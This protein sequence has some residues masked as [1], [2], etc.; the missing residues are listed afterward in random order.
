MRA[1]GGA[2][3]GGDSPITL[4][5]SL[6]LTL[7]RTLQVGLKRVETAREELGGHDAYDIIRSI[8]ALEKALQRFPPAQ[9]PAAVAPAPASAP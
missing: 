9:T 2:K 6:T 4:T 3:E 5:L 7:T 8:E 1:A